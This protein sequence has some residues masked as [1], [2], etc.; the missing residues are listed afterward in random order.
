MARPKAELIDRINVDDFLTIEILTAPGLWAVL[1]KAQAI[2][3]KRLRLTVQGDDFKYMRTT[4][5]S[6]APANNLAKKLNEYFMCDDF[7]VVKVL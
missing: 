7:T 2:N 6:A 4:Y 5:V 3:L 1:Y